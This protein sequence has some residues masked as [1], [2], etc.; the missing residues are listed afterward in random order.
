MKIILEDKDTKYI[1]LVNKD[2]E[3]GEEIPLFCGEKHNYSVSFDVLDIAKANAFVAGIVMTQDTEKIKEIEELIGIR[4]TFLNF[5][6]GHKIKAL[7][8]MLQN[9]L[10]EIDRL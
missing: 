10:F 1:D 9:F 5:V 6:E 4:F 3:N 2:L 7:K 8:E